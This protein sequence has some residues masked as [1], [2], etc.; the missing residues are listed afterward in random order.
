MAGYNRNRYQYE[1]SPRK[2]EP[3]YRPVK[4]KYPKKST[5]TS[6]KTTRKALKTNNKVREKVQIQ[7]KYKAII[8]VLILFSILF[9]ISYRNAV[10]S[11]KYSQIKNMK[12]NLATIQKENEQIEVN[13]ESK[14]NLGTIEKEAKEKLGMKKLNDNQAIYINLNKQD[15]IESAADDVKIE[16]EPNFLQKIIRTIQDLF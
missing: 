16:E 13:I 1:T 11:E 3:E 7:E 6:K 14:T 8:Y 10:I 15:Y 12:S 4:K 5:A 9:A 2:L